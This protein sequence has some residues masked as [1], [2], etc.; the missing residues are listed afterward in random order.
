MEVFHLSVFVQIE[1]AHFQRFSLF[2]HPQGN[3]GVVGQHLR[4]VIREW[5]A[6]MKAKEVVLLVA[7]FLCEL[8]LRVG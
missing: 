2:G 5:C 6:V 3:G 4:V 1:V 8:V 7:V